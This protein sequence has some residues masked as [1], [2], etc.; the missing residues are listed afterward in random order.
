MIDKH[1]KELSAHHLL[2]EVTVH[3][4]N[5]VLQV[6]R[7]VED[8]DVAQ[9]DI[10]VGRK[11]GKEFCNKTAEVELCLS[12]KGRKGEACVQTLKTFKSTLREG[13]KLYNRR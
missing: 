11:I 10:Q 3:G 6:Q 9:K 4:K 13:A 1:S 2:V 12:K 5:L 8:G 7:L